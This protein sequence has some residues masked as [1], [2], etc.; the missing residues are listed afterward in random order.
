MTL[1]SFPH[2]LGRPHKMR[3][4]RGGTRQAASATVTLPA[5]CK[6]AVWDRETLNLE[7][8]DAARRGLELAISRLTTCGAMI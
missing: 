5:G 8:T 3:G 2:E 4:S 6:Y 7:R 1:A